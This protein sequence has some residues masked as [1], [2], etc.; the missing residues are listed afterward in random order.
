MAARAAEVEKSAN[1]TYV[2]K[3]KVLTEDE[4]RAYGYGTP[5]WSPYFIP[6]RMTDIIGKRLKELKSEN[7]S[8]CQ[9][10]C[11]T[12]PTD[13]MSRRPQYGLA[14]KGAATADP[15]LQRLAARRMVAEQ[16][17]RAKVDHTWENMGARPTACEGDLEWTDPNWMR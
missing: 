13:I 3:T 6:D 4:K 9:R 14:P 5:E 10:F 1:R 2:Q 11:A 16:T 15:R 12:R 8:C 7:A 17:A